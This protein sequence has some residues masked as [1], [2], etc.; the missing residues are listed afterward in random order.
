VEPKTGKSRNSITLAPFAL[1]Q[2][3]QHRLRQLEEKLKA[4][5]AWT[6]GD[7]VFS[8]TVGGHLHTSR[9]LFAQFKQLLKAEFFA[10]YMKRT[11]FPFGMKE[12]PLSAIPS[13]EAVL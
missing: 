12:Y 9:I 11:C 2:L 7:R 1:E 8:S 10:V 6:D 4:D 3:K 13:R 5:P